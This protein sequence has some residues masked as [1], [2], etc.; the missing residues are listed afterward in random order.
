MDT[1]ITDYTTDMPE[2]VTPSAGEADPLTVLLP[3]TSTPEPAKMSGSPQETAADEW[4]RQYDERQRKVEEEWKQRKQL[5][6]AEYEALDTKLNSYGDAI[7]LTID[8]AIPTLAEMETFL[9]RKGSN[10]HGSRAQELSLMNFPK[11]SEYLRSFADKYDLS[12][13]SLQRRLHEFRGE[14]NS[15]SHPK[16]DTP[17]VKD[18]TNDEFIAR[19]VAESKDGKDKGDRTRQD[20]TPVIEEPLASALCKEGAHL[21]R[22][23]RKFP[24]LADR[25][26]SF[27]AKLH[28]EEPADVDETP[29]TASALP[30]LAPAPPNTES[31]TDEDDEEAKR[32]ELYPLTSLAD[33][34]FR[35]ADEL[36]CAWGLDG[37][38]DEI[39][40]IGERLE[41]RE[42][43]NERMLKLDELMAS[44]PKGV[45]VSSRYLFK[46]LRR[47]R[48]FQE[49]MRNII[50]AGGTMY[51]GQKILG[52]DD[53]Y[54]WRFT[55]DEIK[56]EMGLGGKENV[57][58][59]RIGVF[60]HLTADDVKN[61]TSPAA[62]TPVQE[63]DSQ[64]EP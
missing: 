14:D 26:N 28:G 5:Y 8:E 10:W 43:L 52:G 48:R 64:P 17:K 24:P 18:E 58:E 59:N 35:I 54:I 63:S 11:W 38:A 1:S 29:V 51:R 33:Y 30:E 25:A 22:L 12:V 42:V 49:D 41:D 20:R 19:L 60:G 4:K 16:R 36:A 3:A 46:N 34:L 61:V 57:L 39:Q 40:A 55:R 50:K 53:P 2:P 32:R 9:S 23:A 7:A 62:S 31:W 13:R 47:D 44:R 6:R 21:A 15:E 37:F 56:A 27:L 45:G